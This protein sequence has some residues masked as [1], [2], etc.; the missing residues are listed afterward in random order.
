MKSIVVINGS[1]KK[2][3]NSLVLA[4]RLC[5]SVKH[6][7]SPINIVVHQLSQEN[8]KQCTG[9]MTCCKTGLCPIDDEMKTIR[10]DLKHANLVIMS[11]PV[12]FGT[13]SSVFQNFVERSLIDLHTFE[14]WGKPVVNIL[15]TNGSGEDDADKYLTRIGLLFGMKKIGMA[16]ISTNDAFRERDFNTLIGK[17]IKSMTLDKRKPSLTNRLYFESM[18]SIIK[19]NPGYFEHESKVWRKRGWLDKS[20]RK[21]KEEINL[22]TT[23]T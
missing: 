16:F 12:H 22:T 20:Y 10:H 3:S 2:E 4:V 13:V 23:S 21:I 6:G 18:K 15:S 7:A 19:K 1:P 14:Y 5:N 8:I 11:S 9:C 17:V